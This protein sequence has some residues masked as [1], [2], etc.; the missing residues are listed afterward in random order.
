MNFVKN[1]IANMFRLTKSD[2]VPPVIIKGIRFLKARIK[3][4]EVIRD[5]FSQLPDLQNVKWILDI[6]A[7]IGE[8]SKLALLSYPE[9]KVVGFEPVKETREQFKKNLASFKERYFLYSDALSDI[10][11]ESEINITNAHGANS[12]SPQSPF[13]K[14]FNPGIHEIATQK[15]VLR[16]LDD[17][18]GELPSN[19]FDIVKMDVEGFELN[20][21]KGGESFFKNNV[22]IVM[23]EISLMRDTSLLEQ[24]AGIIIQYMQSLGFYL[25]N[26]YDLHYVKDKNVPFKIVQ[27]DCV[28]K[29]VVGN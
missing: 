18:V 21:L 25:Y 14:Y 9:A 24:S 29:K 3:K 19:F 5:P 13:H 23:M 28:F 26:I 1:Q 11:G 4:Q 10:N 6:G 16:K 8:V 27:F 15:V 20:I 12:L 22:G 17:M 7:N 2:F